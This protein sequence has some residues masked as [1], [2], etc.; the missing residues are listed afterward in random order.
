MLLPSLVTCLSH[1]WSEKTCRSNKKSYKS[2]FCLFMNDSR[3][4]CTVRL[5]CFHEVTVH[6]SAYNP[7]YTCM[8]PFV[9]QILLGQKKTS[10]KGEQRADI[11]NL[12]WRCWTVNTI[13]HSLKPLQPQSPE[14]KVR[15]K[16]AKGEVWLFQAKC[17]RKTR[18]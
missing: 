11:L 14:E 4:N 1:L 2:W 10:V 18:V 8:Q 12:L 3:L 9:V 16:Q 13:L 6:S 15:I 17:K 7:R 5:R